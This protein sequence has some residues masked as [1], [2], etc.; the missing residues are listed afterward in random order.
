MVRKKP[1]GIPKKIGDVRIKVF[2]NQSD[3]LVWVLSKKNRRLWIERNDLTLRQ[4][5]YLIKNFDKEWEK[6]VRKEL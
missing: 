1:V 3:N 2:V 6:N 5:M 4:L